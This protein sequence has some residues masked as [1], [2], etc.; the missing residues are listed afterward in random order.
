MPSHQQ[1]THHPG[2]CVLFNLQSVLRLKGNAIA[3]ASER[4]TND[5][6]L[7]L[8]IRLKSEQDSS[9][10]GWMIGHRGYKEI[11]CSPIIMEAQLNAIDP[12]TVHVIM[13]QWTR[14]KEDPITR[15]FCL[16][17]G[18]K[19]IAEAFEFAHNRLLFRKKK[20]EQST[21]APCAESE[22][23]EVRDG[24]GVLSGDGVGGISSGSDSEGCNNEG[25]SGEEES[26][27]GEPDELD[28][29]GEM[30]N[31]KDPFSEY[32]SD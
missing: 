22:A 20:V 8:I 27:E 28:W 29:L 5:D 24:S 4:W 23:D 6:E 15:Q 30:P 19:D 18:C 1:I 11:F 26:G 13:R 9:T 3:A 2:N 10:S 12:M 14:R 31:T 16:S 7:P 32:I 17:F 21:A 25:Q